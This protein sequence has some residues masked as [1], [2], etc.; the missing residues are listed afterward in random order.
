VVALQ[1]CNVVVAGGGIGGMTAALLLGSAGASVRLLERVTEPA[2]VGAGI[3]LQPNGLAVL[4]ALGLGGQLQRA[5]WRAPPAAIRDPTGSVLL[6]LPL[7]DFGHG[8]DHALV[9]RR[10]HLYGV[11]LAA[12]RAH[13][14]IQV[15]LGTQVRCASPDGTVGTCQQGVEAVMAADL[16][17]GADGAA[18]TVRAHG[19]FGTVVRATGARYVRADPGTGDQLGWGEYWTPLGLFG[20]APLGDGS[21][22]LYLDAT[23]PP[24]AR[25]LAERDLDGFRGLWAAALPPAASVLDRLGSVEELLVNQV[26]RVDCKRWVDGRL[27]LVGDAAHAMAPNL[28][29]GANSA[30]VDAAVLAAELAAAQP[31]EQALGRYT[32]RRRPAV[33]WVQDAADRLARLSRV[34]NPVLRWG[35][36]VALRRLGR[37][38]TGP[39]RQHR[40]Q[41]E[42]PAWL[43][44]TARRLHRQEAT[45]TDGL[46]GR[47]RSAVQVPRNRCACAAVWWSAVGRGATRWS[48]ADHGDD[49]RHSG[50]RVEQPHRRQRQ[51]AKGDQGD[52]HGREEDTPA[53]ADR[54][55]TYACKQHWQGEHAEHVDAVGLDEGGTQLA[56]LDCTARGRLRLDP[57]IGTGPQ[58][59]PHPRGQREQQAHGHADPGHAPRHLVLLLSR[60]GV[61]GAMP[62]PMRLASRVVWLDGANGTAVALPA[63]GPGQAGRARGVGES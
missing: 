18:S 47:H 12:V 37:L 46:T 54:D 63:S 30:I 10:S 55:K 23:A 50:R 41:Q 22:Y 48:P 8:L 1:G 49:Q 4:D 31:L 58:R 7:P 33:G 36:D 53:G 35:R 26:V 3:L 38:A 17:V 52:H 62:A 9:L 32:A 56:L 27:V 11:L 59:Q 13:P 29:Q 44:A 5:A 28:G 24:V 51:Q 2:A 60:C 19:E 61:D 6:E 40:V 16:V 25:A 15:R 39:R 43:Y 14:A 57:L 21:T 45:D 20:G 42:D 34:S